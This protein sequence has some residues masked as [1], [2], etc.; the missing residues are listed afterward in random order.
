MTSIDLE[1]SDLGLSKNI[2]INSNTK[3]NSIV[4]NLKQNT[5]HV[6]GVDPEMFELFNYYDKYGNKLD[7]DKT[8]SGNGVTSGSKVYATLN[9]DNYYIDNIGGMK[10]TDKK[11]IGNIKKFKNN[12]LTAQ[13]RFEDSEILL[14][15]HKLQL[16]L[17]SMVGGISVL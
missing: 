12:Y 11:Y 1:F 9:T 2:T 7:Y 17:W 16:I 4:D 15:S 14:K 6:E 10:I 13:K 8:L 5:L 3:F